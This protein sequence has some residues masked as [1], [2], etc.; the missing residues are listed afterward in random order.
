MWFSK[1]KQQNRRLA[2]RELLEVKARSAHVRAKRL[3][4]SA[5]VVGVLVGVVVILYVGLS[6]AN[7]VL[8]RFFYQNPT[9]AINQILV[10]T[11]GVISP[12]QIRAW[13]GVRLGQNLVKLDLPALKRNLELVPYIKVAAVERVLPHTLRIRVIERE[14]LAVAYVPRPRGTGGFEMQPVFLDEDGYV[15]PPL[16]PRQLT[17]Q[18]VQNPDQYPAV[19]GINAAELVPGKRLDLTTHAALKAALELVVAFDRSPMVGLDS[20]QRIDVSS[21]DV[22]EVTTQL[23][24]QITFSLTGLDRQLRRWH[25][26]YKLAQ[27][28]G[29]TIASVDLAVSDNIPVRWAT[30]AQ[31]QPA[32]QNPPRPGSGKKRNV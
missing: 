12:E 29:R 17:G 2:R 23:G 3:R 15:L 26:I 9:Y 31:V 11:D 25:E 20:L 18:T 28:L 13:A 27:R 22:L 24:S 30:S 19:L 7:W 5:I 14:P 8:Q 16:E 32:G 1:D 6:A 4:W 10:Y 21:T